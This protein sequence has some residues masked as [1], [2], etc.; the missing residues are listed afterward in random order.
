VP[1]GSRTRLSGL[2]GRRLCRS[3]KGTFFSFKLRRQESNL[4]H[5]G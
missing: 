1:C 5:D 4:R 3:A 2:E